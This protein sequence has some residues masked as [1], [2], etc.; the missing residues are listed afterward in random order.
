MFNSE[1]GLGEM[2]IFF[3][4]GMICCFIYNTFCLTKKLTKNNLVINIVADLASCFLSGALFIIFVFKYSYGDFSVFQLIFLALGIAFVQIFIINSFARLI[5]V[6]YNKVKLRR[7][8]K[9][10]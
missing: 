8:T 7:K 5:F 1:T 10:E 3:V 9:K 2:L 4:L 6:V